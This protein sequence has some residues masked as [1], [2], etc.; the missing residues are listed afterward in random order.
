MTRRSRSTPPAPQPRRHAV[1]DGIPA[2]ADTAPADAAPAAAAITALGP[3]AERADAPLPPTARIGTRALRNTL[4]ILVARAV[5]R[6]IALVTVVL[7]GHVLGD[8][9]FGELQT[10]V[11]YGLMATVVADF[12]LTSL[13]LREGARRPDSISHML[14]FAMSM[15]VFFTAVAGPLLLAGLWFAGIQSLWLP[16]FAIVLL[17]GYLMLLRGTLYALQRLNFEIVEIVPESLLLLGLVILGAYMHAGTAYFLWTYAASYAVAMVYFVIV[18]LTRGFARFSWNLD[19][20]MV[21]PWLR[22]GLPLAIT[23]AFTTVYFK[24]DV[25][26]LQHFRSY[27]EVGWYTLAYKPFEA[28]LFIPVTLRSVIFPIMSIYK[29]VAQHR[30]IPT[31]ERFFKGLAMIGFPITV[32]LFLLSSQFNSLLE[33]YPQSAPAL[34]I[35]SLAVFFAF[36]DNTFAAT[37]NAVDRQTTFAYIALS[38]LGINLVLNL[39]LIPMYGYIAASWTTVITEIAL[40]AIGW[41]VLRAQ[42]GALRV[43]RATWRIYPAGLVMG[44]F[45][46]LV[47][48]EGRVDLLLVTGASAVI[49]AVCIVLFRALDGDEWA[50]LRSIVR[51]RFAG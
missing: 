35:L 19:R 13:Y 39:I 12:G 1:P 38:G 6:I 10:A 32:G 14:G 47:H 28:L 51:E 22:M 33:L 21:T 2:A 40:V 23:Y 18:L 42:V 15:R 3:A 43:V 26:I 41:T 24:L 37:F 7:I 17:G 30:V 27:A 31:A 9:R 20:S 11:T 16:S 45:I 50:A 49:Y 34:H 5:S 4:L 48:P 44:A 25:P 29:R 36:I 8:A 46:L